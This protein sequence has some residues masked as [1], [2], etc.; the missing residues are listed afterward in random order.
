MMKWVLSVESQFFLKASLPVTVLTHEQLMA[1]YMQLF[2]PPAVR[3]PRNS[4][5][6]HIYKPSWFPW[7]LYRDNRI[8]HLLLERCCLMWWCHNAEA[9]AFVIVK[10]EISG[11]V[12][13]VTTSRSVLAYLLSPTLVISDM[14]LLLWG[15]GGKKPCS[16]KGSEG[17]LV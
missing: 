13:S 10:C 9:L 2:A 17:A 8:E 11:D 15:W 1:G 14:N 6:L 5:G 12:S 7:K 16:Y 4:Y 3:K